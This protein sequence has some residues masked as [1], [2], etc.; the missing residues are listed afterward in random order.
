M[1]VA[2]VSPKQ[3]ATGDFY[4]TIVAGPAGVIARQTLAV[5]GVTGASYSSRAFLKAAEKALSK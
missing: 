1:A 4:D 5:D 3:L 2:I